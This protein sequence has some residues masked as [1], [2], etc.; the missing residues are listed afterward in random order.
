M[1]RVLPRA[2][3]VLCLL[4]LVSCAPASP[5]PAGEA[6]PPAA[7][8]PAAPDRTLI[9]GI[10]RE[11]Q[12]LAPFGPLASGLTAAVMSV[13]PFNAFLELID[14]RVG[15]KRHDRLHKRVGVD[16]IT[17]DRLGSQ[18]RE[19]ATFALKRVMPATT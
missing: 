15:P 10:G 6:P 7:S 13:R 8:G 9:V 1:R 5:P 4:A 18:C 16:H 3:M 19:R 12:N 17:D 2:G 11:P 14:D